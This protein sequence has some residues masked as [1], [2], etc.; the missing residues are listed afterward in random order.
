MTASID[1]DKRRLREALK[2]RRARARA[3]PTRPHIAEM[4][5]GKHLADAWP[6]LQ[7]PSPSP[8]IGGFMPIGD[9]LDPVVI[10]DHA[11]LSAARYALPVMSGKGQPLAFRAWSAGDPLVTRQWGIREPTAEA[12][13]VR[14]DILLVP[15]LAFDAEGYRL[16]Y[17]GGFYDRT[18][19]GLRQDSGR[20]LLAI[21]VALDE[22][23][24]D[25]VPRDDYDQPVD[26]ILTPSGYTPVAVSA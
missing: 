25:A 7:W 26:A 6:T 8:I 23:K 2:A 14:P 11:G 18:L 24:L 12:D 17:G 15:L 3:R 10:L 16:G 4:Q 5:M 1:E 22:Q 9:E 19:A 13:D 21:G 20:A